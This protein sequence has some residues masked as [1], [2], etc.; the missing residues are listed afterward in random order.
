MENFNPME[1]RNNLAKDLKEA[2]L[3][4]DTGE[5]EVL[6]DAQ[7]TEEYR[8]ANLVKKAKNNA[9][10]KYGE[11]NFENENNQADRAMEKLGFDIVDISNK[12]PKDVGLLLEESRLSGYSGKNMERVN[13]FYDELTGGKYL[14]KE[15]LNHTSRF[16]PNYESRDT[17]Q[18]NPRDINR[19]KEN[20]LGKRRSFVTPLKIDRQGSGLFFS[21][22][23]NDFMN[24]SRPLMIFSKDNPN[25]V[26]YLLS[27][28]L[29]D[30]GTFLSTETNKFIRNE[31][32]YKESRDFKDVIDKIENDEKILKII[33]DET[34]IVEINGEKIY[35]VK[36]GG[37]HA[38]FSPKVVAFLLL[39]GK[40]FELKRN[41]DGVMIN[42]GYQLDSMKRHGLWNQKDL[43]YSFAT[44]ADTIIDL[45]SHRMYK[46]NKE[47]FL[48]NPKD[49][50]I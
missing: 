27:E 34:E 31:Y 13:S 25:F 32:I 33:V 19:I 24:I 35:Y 6:K 45:P 40:K 48:N 4:N 18:G 17:E 21:G 38:R 5:F 3:K 7:Q 23:R 26:A 16:D 9:I 50:L 42:G 47:K 46:F 43:P 20:F 12:I 2:R 28:L 39:S 14:G 41:Q 15:C 8:V 29:D 49:N 22:G 44:L 1:Y 37:Y 36:D 11:G 30:N 10:E